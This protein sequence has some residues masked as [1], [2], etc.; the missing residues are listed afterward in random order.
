MITPRLSRRVF[1][2]ACAAV[3]ATLA[4][5]PQYVARMAA[6]VEAA[7][8]LPVVWLRGAGCGGDT[9]AFL[10]AAEPTTSTLLFDLL[11]IE[12]HDGLAAAAD[13]RDLA[14]RAAA[15]RAGHGGYLLFLEGAVPGEGTGAATVGGRSF[16]EIAATLADGA[17]A[18]IA[19]GTCAVDGGIA[20]AAGGAT[21]AGGVGGMVPAGR[22]VALPGC[23]V[24]V[25][26]L[27]GTI[28]H[29]LTFKELPP[30]DLR[31]RPL[32]A[33]G[34]LVHNECG[35]RPHFEFGE[36]VQAW[37]DEGAQKGWCLYKMGCKGPETFSPCASVRYAGGT[38]WPVKSGAPCVG[39]HTPGFW[40]ANAPFAERLPPPIAPVPGVT[41]DQ[42]GQAAV[43]GV[44]ALIVA[45]AGASTVRAKRNGYLAARRAHAAA[46]PATEPALKPEAPAES[47]QGITAPA[48]TAREGDAPNGI[49]Q[50][51]GPALQPGPA[52]PSESVQDIIQAP[53]PGEPAD[54]QEG[55]W[56]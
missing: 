40:D 31:G 55:E 36:F 26:N 11:S 37:G 49:A 34:A 38:S 9:E 24:N 29:Y 46:G 8:R 16:R 3:T 27:T 30:T 23:P 48:P 41:V 7:P 54:P 1:L 35:R 43:L 15:L 56:P 42:V 19:L 53:A 2:Q 51:P 39:C 6:A 47:V 25:A 21:G 44:G 4:L 18:T 32:F 17:L 50:P 10:R 45:H 22:F 33:Y 52:V 14:V 28:V 12:M 13:P 20:A 5:P